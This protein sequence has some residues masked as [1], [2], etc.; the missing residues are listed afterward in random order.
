MFFGLW[1]IFPKCHDFNAIDRSDE[2]EEEEFS[3]S[4]PDIAGRPALRGLWWYPTLLPIWTTV[5]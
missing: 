3:C 2:A 4:V 5:A 1:V